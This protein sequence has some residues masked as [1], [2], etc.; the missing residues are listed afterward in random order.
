MQQ[1]PLDLT[2]ARSTLK[3]ARKF[4]EYYDPATAG[5]WPRAVALLARQALEECVRNFW[6]AT[7]PAVCGCS[8]RAQLLS[9][10]EYVEDEISEE[11]RHTWNALSRACH[12]HPYEMAPTSEELAR[13]L[14]SAASVVEELQ[15]FS[16]VNANQR[17]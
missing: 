7:A 14:T 16:S 1:D 10:T 6:Q 11:A 17:D 12:H 15:A 5:M 9:L 4:L 2:E 13:W 8:T 3:Q